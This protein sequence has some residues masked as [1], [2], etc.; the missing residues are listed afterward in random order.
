[1]LQS[2]IPLSPSALPAGTLTAPLVYVG[3]ASPAVVEHI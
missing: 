1:V 2:A 3:Y